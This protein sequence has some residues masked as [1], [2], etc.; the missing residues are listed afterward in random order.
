[1]TESLQSTINSRLRELYFYFLRYRLIWFILSFI[2]FFGFLIRYLAAFN[3]NLMLYFSNDDFGHMSYRSGFNPFSKSSGSLVGIFF[4][5]YGDAHPP[6]RNI[7]LNLLYG[8]I[9]NIYLTRLVSFIPGVLL[10]P[11]GFLFG[12]SLFLNND[13]KVRFYSGL[14][15]SFLIAT[16]ETL[17]LLSVETRPY[18]LMLLFEIMA[19]VS[20]LFVLK[21]KINFQIIFFYLF[22]LLAIFTDYSALVPVA[23]LNI[24]L[25]FCVFK[26]RENKMRFFATMWGSFLLIA[27]VLFQY[28]QLVKFKSTDRFFNFGAEYINVNYIHKISDVPMHLVATFKT[29]FSC[30]GFSVPSLVRYASNDKPY[31]FALT[32]LAIFFL[33]G[34]I[35]LFRKKEYLLFSMTTLVIFI[36]IVASY[37]RLVPFGVGRQNVYILPFLLIPIFYLYAGLLQTR[38]KSIFKVILIIVLLL[39]PWSQG[40]SFSLS[41][42]VK[43]FTVDTDKYLPST[44]RSETFL[45][46]GQWILSESKNKNRIIFVSDLLNTRINNF[47]FF[48]R[49]GMLLESRNNSNNID[50]EEKKFANLLPRSGDFFANN[51]CAFDYAL[52]LNS[53]CTERLKEITSRQ[54]EITFIG[55]ISGR[56]YDQDA[57]KKLGFSVNSE[58]LAKDDW[59]VDSYIKINN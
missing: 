25:L 54:N 22:S 27:G 31:I 39:F 48:T 53:Q 14:V 9:N 8:V 3:Q 21:R 23:G 20:M 16:M 58:I 11:A 15:S 45:K 29:F 24:I 56:D 43:S 46:A 36:A 12:Y 34:L 42:T 41:K 28:L 35:Y 18:S 5:S 50:M 55:L 1:M 44:S 49:I 51:V 52:N 33:L 6:V 19:I 40:F 37:L 30:P 7:L 32:L 10:I 47:V 13:L 4:E 57:M 17:I 59:Y 38:V 26:N 2:V